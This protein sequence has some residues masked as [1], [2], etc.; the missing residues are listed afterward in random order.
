VGKEGSGFLKNRG[1]I[2]L[3]LGFCVFF[4]LEW[5]GPYAPSENLKSLNTIK[6]L[7]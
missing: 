6:W 2:T 1:L 7:D 4:S 5:T 3:K